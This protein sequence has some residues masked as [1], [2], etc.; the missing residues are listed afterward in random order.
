MA[1]PPAFERP[2]SPAPSKVCLLT[3]LARSLLWPTRAWSGTLQSLLR[4][5]KLLSTWLLGIDDVEVPRVIF[6]NDSHIL[7]PLRHGLEPLFLNVR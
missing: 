1:E 4:P 2:V 6:C 3:H 7:D 5:S